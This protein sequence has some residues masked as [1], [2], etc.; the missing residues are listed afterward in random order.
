MT[1][2]EGA[3]RSI[4]VRDHAY[5]AQASEEASTHAIA[6]LQALV[7]DVMITAE[8]YEQYLL[9]HFGDHEK[10]RVDVGVYPDLD[11]MTPEGIGHF[12]DW[13]TGMSSIATLQEETDD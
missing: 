3:G 8:N 4:Q 10:N 12:Y 2:I 5:V 7:P 13:V 1:S 9:K 6:Q 11:V